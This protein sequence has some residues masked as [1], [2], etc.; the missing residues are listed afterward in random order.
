MKY[1][2]RIYSNNY[3]FEDFVGTDEFSLVARA[4]AKVAA[5]LALGYTSHYV[6]SI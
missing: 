5:Y 2:I 6:G 3:G 1:R 4:K